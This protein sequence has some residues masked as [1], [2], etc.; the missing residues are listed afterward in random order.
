VPRHA[1][2]PQPLPQPAPDPAAEQEAPK[3]NPFAQL[4]VLKRGKSSH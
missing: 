1:V 4:A 3:P 2:C